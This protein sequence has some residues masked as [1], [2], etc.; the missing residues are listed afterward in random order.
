[1]EGRGSIFVRIIWCSIEANRSE[2]GDG[3]RKLFYV[4]NILRASP[5]KHCRSVEAGG[6][7]WIVCVCVCGASV[8]INKYV[9]IRQMASP[10]TQIS[11]GVSYLRLNHNGCLNYSRELI[12]IN[13]RTKQFVTFLMYDS[14]EIRQ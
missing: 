8:P 14:R 7:V 11:Y 10:P 3:H 2:F 6:L 12:Q 13:R 1:V 9:H 5:R 4:S